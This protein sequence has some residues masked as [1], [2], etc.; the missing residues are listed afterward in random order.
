MTQ[1]VEHRIVGAPSL[2]PAPAA[3]AANGQ[4]SVRRTSANQALLGLS[5]TVTL[6]TR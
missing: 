3:A 1:S 6:N 4:T 2:A 5:L